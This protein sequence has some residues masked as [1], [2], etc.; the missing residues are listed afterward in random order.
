MDKSSYSETSASLFPSRIET[1]EK[2]VSDVF[3]VTVES[4]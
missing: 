1:L 2:G 4:L 3:I